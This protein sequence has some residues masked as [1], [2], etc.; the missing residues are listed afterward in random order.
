MKLSSATIR[1]E[2]RP[3]NFE[4]VTQRPVT[5][6]NLSVGNYITNIAQWYFI[7]LLKVGLM[8]LRVSNYY[9]IKAEVL[10]ELFHKL[11]QNSFDQY[12]KRRRCQP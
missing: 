9:L 8:P 3:E 2:S 12:E 10:R 6:D 4:L 11:D 7:E 5:Q 1:S